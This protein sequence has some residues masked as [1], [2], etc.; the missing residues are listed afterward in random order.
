[1]VRKGRF[2][3]D[4]G[5]ERNVVEYEPPEDW[6]FS[7]EE[8]FD[9]AEPDDDEDEEMQTPRMRSLVPPVLP[10]PSHKH[11]H[12]REQRIEGT[13]KCGRHLAGADWLHDGLAHR[14]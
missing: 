2:A 3:W 12:R 14:V 7:D 8:D 6:P 10:T 11:H 4:E 13:G 9:A 5:D 1:M